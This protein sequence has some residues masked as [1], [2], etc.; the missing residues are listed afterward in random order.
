MSKVQYWGTGRRKKAVARVRLVP[1]DGT[2]IISDRALKIFP[3]QTSRLIVQQ[4]LNTAMGG[5]LM[6]YAVYTVAVLM[7]R[8]VLSV[9]YCS[10]AGKK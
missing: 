4:P 2:I 7:D 3:E 1:G 8:P 9:R 10:G 5:V 6:S